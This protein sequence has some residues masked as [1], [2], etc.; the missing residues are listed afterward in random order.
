M[1]QRLIKVFSVIGYIVAACVV[2]PILIAYILLSMLIEI[3]LWLI[4]AIIFPV[5]CLDWIITGEF[6]AGDFYNMIHNTKILIFDC[7]I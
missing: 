7:D 5:Y 3:N 2:L 4:E 6:D 1:L